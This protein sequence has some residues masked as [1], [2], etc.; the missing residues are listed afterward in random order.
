MVTGIMR[1]MRRIH[2]TC[3][4]KGT[5]EGS[6]SSSFADTPGGSRGNSVN[7]QA[8]KTTHK[9]LSSAQAKKA[10]PH[11]EAA[12]ITTIAPGAAAL[13]IRAAAWVIP[14][15]KPRRCLATQ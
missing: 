8:Q 14:C 4:D 5:V 1:L 3:F 12:M 11:P 2:G 9:K 10:L 7:V 13:P 15:A 6:S